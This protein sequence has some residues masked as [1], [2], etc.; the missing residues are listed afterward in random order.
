MPVRNLIRRLADLD[1][2]VAKKKARMQRILV[3]AGDNN[4]AGLVDQPF[5]FDDHH[6]GSCVQAIDYVRRR[7]RMNFDMTDNE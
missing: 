5:Q 3:N 7:L 4:P 1:L 2:V 6:S